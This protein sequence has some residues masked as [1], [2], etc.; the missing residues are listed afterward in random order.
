MGDIIDGQTAYP[1]VD[2][3]VAIS[4]IEEEVQSSFPL[5]SLTVIDLP[6]MEVCTEGTKCELDNTH[7]LKFQLFKEAVTTKRVPPE[8]DFRLPEILNPNIIP[9][10][11]P[12]VGQL[13]VRESL[14]IPIC[15]LNFI[16]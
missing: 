1:V 9:A 6:P 15:V 2:L 13:A 14:I 12:T 11:V 4:E 5:Q 3:H 16:M 7:N 10:H 8:D